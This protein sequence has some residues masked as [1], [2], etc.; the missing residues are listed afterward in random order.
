MSAKVSPNQPEIPDFYLPFG[1][2]LDPENRWIKLSA[3]LPWDL[4]DNRYE[5]GK[6][7]PTNP[8]GVGAPALPSRVAFGSLIIK[9]RLGCTDEETVEQVTENPYLQ[10]FLGYT[11]ML[12]DAPFDPSMMVHF[13]KRFDQDDYNEIN[14]SIVIDGVADQCADSEEQ[15]DPKSEEIDPKSEQDNIE[16][17]LDDS[18]PDNTKTQSDEEKEE[19]SHSGKMLI[20]ATATPADITYPTDLKLLNEAREKLELIIDILHQPFKGK[21]KK[22]RT[23]RKVARREYLQITKLK[24]V[25]KNKRRSVIRKQL[26]YVLRNL[27]YVDELVNEHGAKLECLT[28]YQYRCLLVAS[29]I[30]RQQLEMWEKKTNRIAD[31]IVSLSQPWVRPIVRGKQSAKVEFGAKIS[32]SVVGEGYVFLDRMEWDAYNEC[33]DLIGQAEKYHKTFGYWPESIHADK[34]YLTRAN[35]AWCKEKGIRLSGPPLGRPRKETDANAKELKAAAKQQ[36]QDARD[37]NGVEG[38]FGNSKRKGTL[39][40]VMAKLQETSVSVINIGLIVLNLDKRLAWLFYILLKMLRHGP[41]RIVIAD[42]K[43]HA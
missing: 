41:I 12:R 19:P 7:G 40:R 32:I 27:N 23:Y 5:I 9:E 34:I 25:S 18:K 17:E 43:M 16:P 37:R 1:G 3:M 8:A 13:R 2:K 29:E 42:Q 6:A 21:L 20:D 30:Y 26:G 4:V 28:N 24:K 11:E 14:L 33:V 38:K 22:P 15:G 39:N 36:K 35:R 31:R 10:F